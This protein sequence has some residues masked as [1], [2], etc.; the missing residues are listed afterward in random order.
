MQTV[1]ET[2]KL[3]QDSKL[4][5]RPE[6]FPRAGPLSREK[7]MHI[8]MCVYIY[9]YIYMYINGAVLFRAARLTR[10]CLPQ[11]SPAGGWRAGSELKSLRFAAAAGTAVV[12][13]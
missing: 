8:C 3:E 12:D 9:I 10:Q 4:R 6:A 11:S 13:N 7:S 5:K 2:R 1:K